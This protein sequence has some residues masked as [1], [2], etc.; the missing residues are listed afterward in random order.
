MKRTR[1]EK[2]QN[3]NSIWIKQLLVI[4]ITSYFSI[5]SKMPRSN[6]NQAYVHIEKTS[7]TMKNF[8]NSCLPLHSSDAP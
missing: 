6:F 2:K 5:F 7:T 4:F 8:W 3:V 1:T